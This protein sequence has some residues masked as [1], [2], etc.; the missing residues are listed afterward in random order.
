VQKAG[1]DINARNKKGET[2]A[3]VAVRNGNI[4][5]AGILVKTGADITIIDNSGK[6][7]LYELISYYNPVEVLDI[8]KMIEN[9][10]TRDEKGQ[11]LLYYACERK[12]SHI[13]DY[14]LARGV[15]PLHA[16]SNDNTLLMLSIDYDL[17][18]IFRNTLEDKRID[19]N[20]VNKN[21]NSALNLSIL[22]GKYRYF[23]DLL[24]AGADING[25]AGVELPVFAALKSQDKRYIMHLLENKVNLKAANSNGEPLIMALSTRISPDYVK[26]YIKHGA[27]VY[28]KDKNKQTFL[29][30]AAVAGN[31]DLVRFLVEEMKMDIN[32]RDINNKSVLAYAKEAWNDKDKAV[33]KYLKKKGAKE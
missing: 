28:A 8:L 1:V 26:L 13:I 24:E 23:L 22:S 16:D 32:A 2:A 4:K 27:D 11:N 29:M 18:S 30:K 9:V 12:Q 3:I 15:S 19:I 10:N 14:L 5:T 20:A 33:Y 21:G 25:G 17:Y 6:S 7:F 31:L